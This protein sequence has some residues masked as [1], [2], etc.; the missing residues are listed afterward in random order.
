[1]L[2]RLSGVHSLL[3]QTVW[4]ISIISWRIKRANSEHTCQL[5]SSLQ[6]STYEN[7]IALAD[8]WSPMISAAMCWNV[9][10]HLCAKRWHKSACVTV[11][12]SGPE[13]IKLFYVLN[14]AE[15]E[16]LSAKKY[17]NVN[18]NWHFHISSQRKFHAQLCLARQTL[19]LFVIW[20]L[21]AEQIS[22]SAELSMKKVL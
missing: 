8:D 11:C 18:K 7:L 17:K 16:I 13:V 2:K 5:A 1:M 20:D 14:S 10:S 4:C 6:L 3:S 15:H 22:C 9:P 19:Q 21:L 12:W